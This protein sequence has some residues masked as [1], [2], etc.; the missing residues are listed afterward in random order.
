MGTC[1]LIVHKYL[2]LKEI[3]GITGVEN[4]MYCQNTV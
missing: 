3:T 2:T 4:K 1:S